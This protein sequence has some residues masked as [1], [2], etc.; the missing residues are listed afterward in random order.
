MSVNESK[1]KSDKKR[2]VDNEKSDIKFRNKMA[3][4][5]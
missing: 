4:S 1:F 3:I 2:Q 5:F